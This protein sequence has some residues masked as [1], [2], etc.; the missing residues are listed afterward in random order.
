MTVQ[1]RVNAAIDAVKRGQQARADYMAEITKLRPMLP[2]QR[3]AGRAKLLECIGRRY[4][5]PIVEGAGK[6]TGEMVLDSEAAGYEAAKTALRRMVDDIYGKL[7]EGS[8]KADPVAKLLES[9]R[10]LTAAQKRS[11]KAQL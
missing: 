6:K 1:S 10:A 4:G 2:R 5:V 9:Y 11:F 8:S 7:T 3:E